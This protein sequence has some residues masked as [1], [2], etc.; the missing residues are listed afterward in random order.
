M[1]QVWR[2]YLFYS[3]DLLSKWLPAENS[4]RHS[5]QLEDKIRDLNAKLEDSGENLRKY[6]HEINVT[7][8]NSVYCISYYLLL[9][10]ENE[11]YEGGKREDQDRT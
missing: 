8:A 1:N 5:G 11:V 4:S 7:S 2:L 10:F 9:G 3:H 6:E